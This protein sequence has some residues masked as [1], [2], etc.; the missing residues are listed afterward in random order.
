MSYRKI[1]PRILIR[2][3]YGACF[4]FYTE[5]LGLIPLYSDRNG[6]YTG[7]ALKEGEPACFATFDGT[8]L[9]EIKGY[10]QPAETVQSDTVMIFIPSDDFNADF[11][12]LK[13]EGVEFF[14]EPQ[15]FESWG[16]V[17]SIALLK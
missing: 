17:T 8:G 16:G 2:K 7:F 9:S 3:D 5:K 12:R 10:I 11:K 15:Y 14:G 13:D 6:P 1:T 4:D